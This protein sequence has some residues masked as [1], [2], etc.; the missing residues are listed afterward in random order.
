MSLCLLKLQEYQISRFQEEHFEMPVMLTGGS[1]DF[2]PL[3]F[4]QMG[5][6]QMDNC[7]NGCAC[8]N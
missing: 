1:D 8:G 6:G 5:F 7:I 3:D 2:E 4:E